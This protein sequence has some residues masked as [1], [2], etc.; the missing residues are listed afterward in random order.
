LENAKLEA[1]E[2]KS[3]LE[4]SLKAEIARLRDEKEEQ[5]KAIESKFDALSQELKQLQKP[6]LPW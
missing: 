3:K 1:E 5:S 6:Q 4:E 2:A